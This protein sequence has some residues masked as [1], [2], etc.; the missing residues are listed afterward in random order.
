MGK[1]REGNGQNFK[2]P[3]FTFGCFHCIDDFSKNS[4]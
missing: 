3:E 1:M 2:D 4:Q